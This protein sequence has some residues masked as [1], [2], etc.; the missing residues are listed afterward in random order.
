[1]LHLRRKARLGHGCLYFSF[2]KL[3]ACACDFWP[4]LRLLAGRFGVRGI[5]D[6]AR[7]SVPS[8][9]DLSL[10][11]PFLGDVR[12]C[13]YPRPITTEGAGDSAETP[14]AYDSTEPSAH[15]KASFRPPPPLLHPL[16]MLSPFPREQGKRDSRLAKEAHRGN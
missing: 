16:E 12:A 4:A 1:V 7:P 3:F 11:R 6:S 14:P 9:L 8:R 10:T 5:E 13:V 15:N 2:I